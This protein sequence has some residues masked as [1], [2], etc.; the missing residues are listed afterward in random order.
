MLLS[1]IIFRSEI[2]NTFLGKEFWILSAR[3]A[4]NALIVAS[5]IVPFWLAAATVENN[6]LENCS[7]LVRFSTAGIFA[8]GV[9][10]VFLVAIRFFTV[11][12]SDTPGVVS[13]LVGSS[14]Y[15]LSCQSGIP[16]PSVSLLTESSIVMLL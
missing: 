11:K 9:S 6:S 12:L 4:L 14:P 10:V 15:K 5:S 13:A 2:K 7:V 8:S 3:L 16:S 1:F